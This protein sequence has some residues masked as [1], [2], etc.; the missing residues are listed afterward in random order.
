M[1][2]SLDTLGN[3]ETRP[4]K[5]SAPR[6]EDKE[7]DQNSK[8]ELQSSEKNR[9]ENLMIVDLMRNDLSRNC[10][11]GSVSVDSLFD[12]TTYATVHHMSSTIRGKKKPDIAT[13]DL[14]KGCFPP[15]SMT[16][17]PKIKA[18]ELCSELEQQARGVYS[19]AIGWFSGD[20]ACD[21]SV[22]IRTLIMQGRRFEF[23]VGG[24]IVSDSDPIEEWRETL[25]KA[26]GIAKALD[27]PIE[28][29]A[30]L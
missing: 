7:K 11:T 14:V 2:L 8:N 3:V 27:I 26:R 30:Q 1:F 13:L 24:A 20:G 22:V 5:G 17:A 12:V 18:M 16:G 25:T 10:V 6:F 19:G 23:Q 21:F 29:L 15:G 28:K 9:A 4:I